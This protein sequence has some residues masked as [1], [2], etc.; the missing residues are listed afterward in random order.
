MPDGEST[1]AK[2]RRVEQELGH[3]RAEVAR[4][5]GLLRLERHTT[6]QLRQR[7]N[8]VVAAADLANAELATARAELERLRAQP[9]DRE[10]E[11][12]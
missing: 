11:A 10:G 9:T 2:L 6:A 5:G 8:T 12:T 7:L 4:L 3:F 1:S